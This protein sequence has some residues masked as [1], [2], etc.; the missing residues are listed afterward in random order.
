VLAAI[1]NTKDF[2]G[3]LGRWRFAASGDITLTTMSGD[4]I[5]K[6]KFMFVGLLQ[7]E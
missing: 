5:R 6:G 3:I 4:Q 7:A 2:D 1:V